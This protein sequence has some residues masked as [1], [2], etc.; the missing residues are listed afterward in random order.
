MS[1]SI[2][3]GYALRR[4]LERDLILRR[5]VAQHFRAVR[6][7][8]ELERS[9]AESIAQAQGAADQARSASVPVAQN[10]EQVGAA[11]RAPYEAANADT[12]AKVRALYDVLPKDMVAPSGDIAA[13]AKAIQAQNHSRGGR[14]LLKL[15]SSP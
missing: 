2:S 6:D 5:R 8:L 13:K 3:D 9:G 10:P 7:A 12:A 11:L 1:S 4:C 14:A 15:M